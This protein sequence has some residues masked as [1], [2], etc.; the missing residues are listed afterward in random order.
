MDTPTLES[1]LSEPDDRRIYLLARAFKEGYSI[2]RLY[3]LTKID[4]WFLHKLKNLHDLEIRMSTFGT[5][6]SVPLEVMLRAKQLGFSDKQIAR[7]V[8]STELTVRKRE[9]RE[10]SQY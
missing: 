3:D 4:K 8:A 6:A 1:L 10:E 9:K 5:A 2:D 7:C